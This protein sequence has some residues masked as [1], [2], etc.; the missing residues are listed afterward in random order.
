MLTDNSRKSRRP[1]RRPGLGFALRRLPRYGIAG[2]LIMLA[3]EV[4]L[5]AGAEW[6]AQWF[7]PIM[8]TGYILFIDGVIR[9][10][11]GTSLLSRY[12]REFV[13]LAV[14]SIASWE[15]F[16]GYNLL[17]KNWR[18]INL[19]DPLAVR[20]IGYAWSY[21]TISPAMFLTY[22][23]LEDL[24][25]GRNPERSPRLGNAPFY[26]LVAFGFACIS[27]PLVWPSAYMT[28]LVWI[29]WAFFLDPI[30]QRL[31]ERS[32]ISELFSGKAR[33]ILI[34]FLAGFLCGVIWEFW[35]YWAATKWE[36]EVPYL[37]HIKIFEMPV[38]GFLGFLPFAVESYAIYVFLRRL[39]PV[40]RRVK[41]LG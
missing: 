19:P 13:L 20:L 37:G 10:R 38:L 11:K 9:A 8:W 5:F 12:P 16:E 2:F 17:L 26:A 7:T 14:I 3:G 25:P 28:P 41:Y 34:M 18:Y 24:L 27:V 22:E 4:T 40:E 35:N 21:A 39:I 32:F 33:S 1:A 30:N 29:G 31:G 15:I 6:I 23:L 36:Y